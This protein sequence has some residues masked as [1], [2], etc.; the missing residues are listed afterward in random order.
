MKRWVGQ[1]RI[2]MHDRRIDVADLGLSYIADKKVLGISEAQIDREKRISKLAHQLQKDKEQVLSEVSAATGAPRDAIEAA[3]TAATWPPATAALTSDAPQWQ[4]HYVLVLVKLTACTAGPQ[5]SR[6]ISI[7]IPGSTEKLPTAIAQLRK[8]L[9]ASTAR[10]SHLLSNLGWRGPVN[11]LATTDSFKN[12]FEIIRAQQLASFQDTIEDTA[13]AYHH[14]EA[15][16]ASRKPKRGTEVRE[17]YDVKSKLFT[18]VCLQLRKHA[19]WKSFVLSTC[20]SSAELSKEQV[21]DRADACVT[22]PAC[23]P[24]EA[25]AAPGRGH[26]LLSDSVLRSLKIIDAELARCKEEQHIIVAERRRT[27]AAFEGSVNR[28]TTAI[29]TVTHQITASGNRSQLLGRQQ[30][31]EVRLYSAKRLL[32]RHIH[33]DGKRAR[34]QQLATGAHPRPR[35]RVEPRPDTDSDRDSHDTSGDSDSGASETSGCSDPDRF[36]S[37]NK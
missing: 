23:F 19:W 31:L 18:K 12:V 6:A 8:Q 25:S 21:E 26:T 35:V 3:V 28:L 4:L 10:H 20:C 15:V 17:L 9:V 22:V 33:L 1:L 13:R 11:E 27:Q 16:R 2:M 37:D 36:R 14:E 32:Q 5:A 29:E 24:W 7:L 30:L 34:A